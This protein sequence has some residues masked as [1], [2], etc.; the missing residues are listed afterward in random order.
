MLEATAAA[1]AAER[2]TDHDLL[3]QLTWIASM[4]ESVETADQ[5]SMA[6][7]NR[8]FHH[9]VWAGAHH[10]PLLDL[11]QLLDLHVGRYS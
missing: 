7:Y 5:A 11:L 3:R 4:S 6:E 9:A 1:L 2:R 8:R 10:D